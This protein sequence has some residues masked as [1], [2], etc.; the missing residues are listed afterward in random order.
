[1]SI[2]GILEP[3]LQV[4]TIGQLKLV[5]EQINT[6]QVALNNKLKGI[7]GKKIKLPAVK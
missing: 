1:M 4:V 3:D 6:G 5:V 7:G 2:A